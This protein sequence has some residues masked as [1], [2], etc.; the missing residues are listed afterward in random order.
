MKNK[1]FKA[2]FESLYEILAFIRDNVLNNGFSEG[3]CN[4]I[5]LA[6]EEV[7]VNIIKHG[8]PDSGGEL[9]VTCES[10]RDQ[11][12]IAIV[13]IDQGVPFNPI[14][15]VSD[16]KKITSVDELLKTGYGIYFFAKIMD[17]VNYQRDADKNILYMV[18]HL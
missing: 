7:V 1:R 8:Y 3:V 17:R 4:Q 18:R 2:S 15:K 5:V 10:C 11:P 16:P 14:D 9:E 12:G 6:A 13:I